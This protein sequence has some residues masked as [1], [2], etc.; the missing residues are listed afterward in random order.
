MNGKV[1]GPMTA[2]LHVDLT[3]RRDLTAQIYQQL[4]DAILDGRLTAGQRLPPTRRLAERLAVA[5][6]TVAAAYDRLTAEGFLVGKV[7]AGAA[8]RRS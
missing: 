6:N 1:I 7:G 4:L 8:A 5:R 2:E 3:G